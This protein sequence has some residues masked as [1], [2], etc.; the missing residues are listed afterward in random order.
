[1]GKVIFT[2]SYDITPEKRDEYLAL[3]NEMKQTL[4]QRSASYSVYEQKGR[5]NAFSEIFVFN[6]LDEYEQMEDQ[7][8]QTTAYLSRLESMLAKGKMKYSTLVE[9]A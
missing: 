6:S 2:V 8:E 3:V 4:A 5:K 1:M 7:D 9:V